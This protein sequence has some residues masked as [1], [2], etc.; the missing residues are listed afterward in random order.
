MAQM[1]LTENL[2]EKNISLVDHNVPHSMGPMAKNW[3]YQ[4]T[5]P[6]GKLQ[7][8]EQEIRPGTL[9]I[10]VRDVCCMSDC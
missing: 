8:G 3:E 1:G 2:G 4:Q 5:N 10:S 6:H 7:G 9:H